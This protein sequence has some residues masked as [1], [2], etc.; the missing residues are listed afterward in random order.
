MNNTSLCLGITTDLSQP[1]CPGIRT[2]SRWASRQGDPSQDEFL[3]TLDNSDEEVKANSFKTFDASEGKRLNFYQ[4][5]RNTVIYLPGFDW[6]LFPPDFGRSSGFLRWFWAV[7]PHFSAWWAGRVWQRLQGTY[8]PPSVRC[9]LSGG[10]GRTGLQ[11]LLISLADD[12]RLA[13]HQSVTW[14]V[15]LMRSIPHDRR[16]PSLGRPLRLMAEYMCCCFTL[17][18]GSNVWLE[19]MGAPTTACQLSEASIKT[20]TW[21]GDAQQLSL[22]KNTWICQIPFSA[23]VANICQKLRRT[24]PGAFFI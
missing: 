15:L 3:F 19:K 8:A 13:V 21:T 18:T 22:C 20:F 10:R 16:H 11:S 4:F 23:D 5:T 1:A 14:G 9:G 24:N 7:G 17:K 2:R 6:S 12:W